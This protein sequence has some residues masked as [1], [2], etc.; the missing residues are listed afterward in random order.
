[1]HDQIQIKQGPGKKRG[2]ACCELNRE[3]ILEWTEWP[4]SEEQHAEG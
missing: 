4:I 1:M 2:N 3:A